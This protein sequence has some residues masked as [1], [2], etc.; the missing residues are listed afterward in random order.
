MGGGGEGPPEPTRG[1]RA[2]RIID[3]ACEA[4]AHAG[5]ALISA[6]MVLQIV[7]VVG[8]KTIGF[9]ILGLSEIGQL[10]VMGC[11]CLTW[12]LVFGRDGHI[13]VEFVTDPL[14]RRSLAAL[15]AAVGLVGAIF[16]GALAYYG[17]GQAQ[18]QIA[19]GDISSTLHIPILWYWIPLLL[20]MTASGIACLA[21]AI[22]HALAA[23][24]GDSPRSAESSTA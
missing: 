23:A 1:S 7:E 5:I 6:F 9:S 16:V 14:P 18:A 21:Q 24:L 4:L 12:P 19:K 11:I 8:R 10:F 20:G 17:F 13:A 15:K 3:V 2:L 22:R